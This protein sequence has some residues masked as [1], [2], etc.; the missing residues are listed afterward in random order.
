V[1]SVDLHGDR[2][3]HAFSPQREGP[4][5][6]EVGCPGRTPRLPRP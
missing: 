3:V 5:G 6:T 2:L 4:P 1:S